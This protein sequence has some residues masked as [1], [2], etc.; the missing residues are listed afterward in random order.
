MARSV[1]LP[2]PFGPSTIVTRPA[3]NVTDTPRSA[4][5]LPYVFVTERSTTTSSKT[6]V[7]N[8]RSLP[9]FLRRTQELA[10]V[11]QAQNVVPEAA[12][13]WSQN[14]RACEHM[15]NT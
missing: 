8:A 6:L 14:V 3:S 15:A 1:D 13:A 7:P 5:T 11:R 9:C 12:L 10:K 4:R 2:E